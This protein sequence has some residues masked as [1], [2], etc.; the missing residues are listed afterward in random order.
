MRYPS[1]INT[2]C[3]I[4]FASYAI[5]SELGR[6]VVPEFHCGAKYQ[7]THVIKGKAIPVPAATQMRNTTELKAFC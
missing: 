4:R 7:F 3:A 1:D 2:K 5:E 6:T